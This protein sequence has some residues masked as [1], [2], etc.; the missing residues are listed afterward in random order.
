MI[1]FMNDD[2]EVIELDWLIQLVARVGLDNV[3]AVGP[4]LY[5]PDD[6]IQHAGVI[7]GMGGVAGH[8]FSRLSRENPGYFGRAALEQ[9]LSCVTAA[10][11]VARRTAFDQ[12]KGFNEDLPVAFNDVDFCLRLRSAGWR[13]VWTPRVALYHH[14]SASLGKHDAPARREQF[15]RDVATMTRL[16]GATI[17]NDPFFN[18]NLALDSGNYL[19]AFPPRITKLRPYIEQAAPRN[20]STP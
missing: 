20:V 9:D 2:V 1:C 10:C 12:V 13:I 14:K 7:I 11:M 3:G 8:Q 16:W 6:T 18:P 5:Y 19:I 4:M 17:Q 15:E